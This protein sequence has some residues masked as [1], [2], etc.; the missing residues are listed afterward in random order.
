MRKIYTSMIFKVMK[1]K[2]NASM[3]IVKQH[4][5]YEVAIVTADGCFCTEYYWG[6][7]DRRLY[8]RE[9]FAGITG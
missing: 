8:G 3:Y 2:N 5:G 9:N 7:R 1:V 6:L 4:T